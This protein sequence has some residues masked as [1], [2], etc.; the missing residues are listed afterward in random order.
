VKRNE[1]ERK[2]SQEKEEKRVSHGEASLSE[3]KKPAHGQSSV[4]PSPNRARWQN[5]LGCRTI[6]SLPGS[7]LGRVRCERV[8]LPSRGECGHAVRGK[9]SPLL[10]MAKRQREAACS[11]RPVDVARAAGKRVGALCDSNPAR[12]ATLDQ[13]G[14]DGATRSPASVSSWHFPPIGTGRAKGR[15]DNCGCWRHTPRAGCHRLRA[16]A[17]AGSTCC[18]LDSGASHQAGEES[19]LR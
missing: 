11:P 13:P 19:R 10:G 6:G 4:K 9:C 16:A 5:L 2:K 1:E 15:G 18:L 3:K 8:V 17:P 14:G 12:G 7:L